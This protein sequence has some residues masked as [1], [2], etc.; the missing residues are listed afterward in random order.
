MAYPSVNDLL[1]HLG[2]TDQNDSV[3]I[4]EYRAAAIAYIEGPD[5]AQRKYQVD[6]DTTRVFDA[7][8][9]IEGLVLEL[10][11]DLVSITT[12]TNGDGVAIS[13]S[14]YVLEGPGG[15]RNSAPYRRVRLKASSGVQW[16]YLTDPE[17]AISIVG[18]W[19]Y[20]VSAPDRAAQWVRELTGWLYRRRAA[21]R[22]G[23]D[24]RAMLTGDGVTLLPSS[25]PQHIRSQLYRERTVAL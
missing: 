11:H 10:D 2:L 6:A 24:D 16:R 20:S 3:L 22:D 15:E 21:Q 8:R 19:G 23:S 12:L 7:I 5:G 17:G 18:R 14:A 25:V 4:A 9:D 1:R 13:A